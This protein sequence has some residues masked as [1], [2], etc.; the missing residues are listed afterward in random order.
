MSAATDSSV[1]GDWIGFYTLPDGTPPTRFDAA[2]LERA[3]KITG[4]IEEVDEHWGNGHLVST[5]D[6][7]R[8]GQAIRFAKFYDSGDEA[9]DTVVYE[10]VIDAEG[11][12][13]SGTWQVPEDWSGTFI[14]TRL[15][16]AEADIAIHRTISVD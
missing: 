7:T 6:G 9:F 10:G 13:I 5:V 12:E 1:S 15:K 11:T 8:T 3:G 4:S 14:M 2:L 16:A